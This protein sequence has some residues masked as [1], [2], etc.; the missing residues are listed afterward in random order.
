MGMDSSA[1]APQPVRVVLN[2]VGQ[3]IGR[4]GRIWVEG[5]IAELNRRGRMA[6]ITLRDPVANV[7]VRVVCQTSVLDAQSPPPEPGARVVVHAKPD[8]YEVRGT[9]SLR[10]LE[11]R[12]VGLGELLARLE[13]LRRTLTAEGLFDAARK[14]PLPFLPNTVGLICGRDSAAE[15][16]VLENGRRRW[17]AVRFEVRPVA[18]QG[19]RAVR[20]VTEALKDLD[21]HPDV[22]VIVIARGGG[23]L[24]DLLPFSDEALVRAVA[25]A[26]TP[27]VSA[28]G[29]EQDAP[30]LDHVADVRASTPTDAAKKTIPDVG[31]QL[32]IIRQLR[33]RGRRV[34][35]GGVERELAWLEGVRSRPA[36][37]SP[38]REVDRLAEQVADL[39]DRARRS[40]TVSLDRSADGLGHTRARLHALSPATTLARGYAIVQRE[41]GS[42]VRSAR[43]PDAGESLRVRFAE[44]SLTATV[45]SVHTEDTSE[46]G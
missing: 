1:E 5:Q 18:V 17:P 45:E 25:S 43:E 2:A 30:L 9:F 3:W 46:E 7:S 13:Q 33:D 23:S 35:R 32:E 44:D 26:G 14:R 37:A 16:D 15:R 34:L 36:L 38:V 21:S 24:E 39:R 6:Y 22:D 31:E 40:L 10:A 28:I 8:F 11:I 12:H 27:V 4:L 20:E 29:H 42:V 41:D 19:D